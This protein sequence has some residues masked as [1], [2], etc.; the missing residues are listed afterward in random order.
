MLNP[1]TL[2]HW[3]N[4][5]LKSNKGYVASYTLRQSDRELFTINLHKQMGF[6]QI[7]E[8]VAPDSE[9]NFIMEQTN[10]VGRCKIAAFDKDTGNMLGI[11]KG[12][13]L[14]DTSE[15]PVF[16]VHDLAYLS[17][18]TVCPTNLSTPDDYAAVLTG[19]RTV[20]ALFTQLPRRG[21]QGPGLFGRLRQRLKGL[22]GGHQDVMEIDIL[23]E[24]GC[25]PRMHCAI[26]VI[27][28]SR[29]GLQLG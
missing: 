15:Q 23:E 21:A 26:A 7:S 4:P 27:L 17:E 8:F 3:I 14:V 19:E 10:K 2:S 1:I 11:F 6:Y 22:L 18:T 16:E 20:A 24:P 13:I 9:N 12:N 28:H 5:D 29:R 25:D